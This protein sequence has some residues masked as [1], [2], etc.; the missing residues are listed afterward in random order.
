VF[1]RR[2]IEPVVLLVPRRA[3]GLCR[4]R[5][6]LGDPEQRSGRREP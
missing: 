5:R 3:G 4:G 1:L 2:L 6:R